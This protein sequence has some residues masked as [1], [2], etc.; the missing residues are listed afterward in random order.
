M[1]SNRRFILQRVIR[2]E[3]I[4]ATSFKTDLDELGYAVMN[5]YAHWA[6]R[7]WKQLA[8]PTETAATAKEAEA[9]VAVKASGNGVSRTASREGT[10]ATGKSVRK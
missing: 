4:T 10:T 7:G 2:N 5:T 9:D 1:T 6:V 8:A 3:N